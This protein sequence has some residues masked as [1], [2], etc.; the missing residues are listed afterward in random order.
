MAREAG[1]WRVAK[2]AAWSGRVGVTRTTSSS[3]PSPPSSCRRPS[4]LP[5]PPTAGSR[6]APCLRAAPTLLRTVS[7]DGEPRATHGWP[8]A[9]PPHCAGAARRQP[10]RQEGGTVA[11]TS[12]SP[13]AVNPHLAFSRRPRH[14]TRQRLWP[15]LPLLPLLSCHPAAACRRPPSLSSLPFRPAD[16]PARRQRR[17]RKGEEGKERG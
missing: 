4:P 16:W 11:P 1:R 6:A 13:M 8:T 3:S 7:P 15:L 12:P 2:P 10:R 9:A 17:E 5:P 14:L